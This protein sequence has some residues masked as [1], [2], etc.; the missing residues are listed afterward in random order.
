MNG[1]IVAGDGR[2]AVARGRRTSAMAYGISEEAANM[3]HRS[4]TAS[5]FCGGLLPASVVILTLAGCANLKPDA[6]VNEAADLVEEHTGHRPAWTAPW[7]GQ[8]PAWDGKALLSLEAAV[9]TALRNNRDLRADLEMI[10]QA[11]A[12]LVQAGLLQNPTINFM[13]MFP[14]GGGRSMLWSNGL[15]TM[16]LQD[17]W[18]IPARKEVATAQLQRAVLRVA[19]RAVE[20]A[21]AVKKVYARLQYTQR[22]IEVI[23]DN[24]ALVDQSTQMVQARQATGKAT[25]LMTNML[26]IRRLRLRSDLLAMEAEHRASKR[27]LLMIMGLAS[28]TDRWTVTPMHEREDSLEVPPDEAGLLVLA[29]KQRLD[30]KAAEWTA[31]AAERNIKLVQREGWPDVAVGFGFQRSPAPPSQNQRV[32]GTLGN[33]AAQGGVNGLFGVAPWPPGPPAVSPFNPKAREVKYAMG[34]MVDLEIPIFDWNQAQ[35]AKALHEYRQRVAE[36]EARVQE[37]TRTVRETL[38][39]YRQACDQ[40]R[41]YRDSVLP[42]VDENLA[43]TQQFYVLEQGELMA[44]LQGQEDVLMARMKVLE[45]FRDYLVNRA[46]L[47]RQVGGRLTVPATTTQ[48]TT[49]PAEE[50]PAEQGA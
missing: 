28:A 16:P 15:P 35:A 1:A 39:V 37:V 3:L 40:V 44:Y 38:V 8:P 47:E 45:F 33:A 30:V 27:E 32:A 46:E 49:A 34:P 23:N 48:P 17:L 29:G 21:A 10:G 25:Q 31:Q 18:L 12:D 9:V 50:K 36:Y 20:T 4:H 11:N 6:K 24:M 7:D 5:R 14:D 2:T 43:L 41:F 42:A 26:V 19:D 22:A 13:L